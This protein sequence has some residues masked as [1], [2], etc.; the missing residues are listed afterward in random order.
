[1]LY[2]SPAY[3]AVWGQSR[4]ALY[5]EPRSFVATIHPDDHS[6]VV[7]IMDGDR[8]EEF[9]VEYRVVRP[10]G[11][12]RWIWNR[13]FPINDDSGRFY[14]LAGLA[15][16][17]TQ[18]K[19]AEDTLKATG[20]QVRALSARVQSAREEEGSRIARE[21]HD[22]LGST[23]TSL[24]FDLALIRREELA[25]TSDADPSRLRA[26]LDTMM[27]AIDQ[28]VDTVRRI[29]SELR[30][31]VLDDIGLVAAIRWQAKQFE[32]QAGIVCRCDVLLEDVELDQQ[33][34]TAIFRV[35]QEALTNV[36]RHARAT[37]VNVT[38]ETEDDELA[39]TVVDN[40]QGIAADQQSHRLSLGLLGM[41][42]R[43]NLI[44]GTIQITGVEGEGTTITV[45]VPIR[46]QS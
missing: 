13:G 25:S 44:G 17:V 32:A 3:E 6:R 35:F 30:P 14:R 40:G 8:D 26:K 5:R 27:Q 11:S 10:D 7:A 16:D 2:V 29:S 38:L 18:R 39:L 23:L 4:A 43:V 34:S 31:S 37:R 9:D 20:E 28:T 12:I 41:R 45:R 24:K 19:Q 36:L 15:E 21:L 33:Q 46:R 42:E 22:E 1:M